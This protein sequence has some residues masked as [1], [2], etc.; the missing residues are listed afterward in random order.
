VRDAVALQATLAEEK[1]LRLETDVADDLPDAWADP[2][3]VWRVLQNLVGN[4]VK[5]TPRGGR[6][7]VTAGLEPR[8]SSARML[9]VAVSD[10]GP[11]VP[12]EVRGRLFEKFAA[13]GP[14]RGSG[15]GLAFCRLAV[16]AQ[17]GRIWA[18]S[19]PEKGSTFAFT[20]PAAE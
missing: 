12:A 15:L 6:V 3:L 10:T 4:A 13:A 14:G 11:G 16:E 1:Q 2:D 18:E 8:A 7:R 9:R 20:L 17:G 5:F 19:E